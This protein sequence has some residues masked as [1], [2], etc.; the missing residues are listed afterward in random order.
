MELVDRNIS[1]K[2]FVESLN[3]LVFLPSVIRTSN[4]SDIFGSLKNYS[5]HFLNRKI[6]RTIK[7]INEGKMDM[8][9]IK[10]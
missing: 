6:E 7:N 2:T 4:D 10:R 9:K 5:G 1:T 3:L 8:A